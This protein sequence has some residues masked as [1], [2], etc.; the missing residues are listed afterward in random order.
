M[1]RFVLFVPGSTSFIHHFLGTQKAVKRRKYDVIYQTLY[2]SYRDP[3]GSRN[4]EDSSEER[5]KLSVSFSGSHSPKLLVSITTNQLAR[6]VLVA[7]ENDSLGGLELE[8]EINNFCHFLLGCATLN[9]ILTAEV[10]G[11]VLWFSSS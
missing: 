6:S 10:V 3:E 4:E 5:L 8:N 7:G 2:R 1:R 9:W 11:V